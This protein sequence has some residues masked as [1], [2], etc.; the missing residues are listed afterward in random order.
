MLN[1]LDTARNVN[2]KVDYQN[3]SSIEKPGS[4]GRNFSLINQ[5]VQG[6]RS[7]KVTFGRQ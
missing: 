3:Y 4:Q 7:L 6:S 1:M 2:S 5:P